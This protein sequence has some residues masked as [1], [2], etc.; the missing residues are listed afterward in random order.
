M[1]TLWVI[2][3]LIIAATAVSVL[4]A[5]FSVL[6]LRDL[7]SGAAIAVMAMAGSLEFAKFV[8]AAYLHQRWKFLHLFFRSYLLLAIVILSVI[9]SMG[10]FG[11]LSNAYQSASATLEA[12]NIKLDALKGQQA[13]NSA[14]IARMQK[15]ID[16]IPANRVTKKMAARAEAEPVINSLTKQTENLATQVDAANLK[17]L[18][19][20]QK[21]GPLIYI[22]KAFKLDLDEIVKYLILVLVSVFDPLAICLVIATSESLQARRLAKLQPQQA[23]PAPVQNPFPAPVAVPVQNEVQAPVQ[24]IASE[25]GPLT[26]GDVIQMRFADDDKDRNAV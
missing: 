15:A 11:F 12:E 3:G 24:A 2:F 1:V 9:T 8:L 23:A 18:E 25:P 5:S 19:V 6:G 21:V 16:E 17:I 14:E 7:F 10:I 26:S 22:S 20:K 4:G 13:R